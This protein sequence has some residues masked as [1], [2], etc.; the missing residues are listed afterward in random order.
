MYNFQVNQ[1]SLQALLAQNADE[2]ASLLAF[3]ADFE[4]KLA[5]LLVVCLC[6]LCVPNLII[7]LNKGESREYEI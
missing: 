3:K 4:A 1:N 2:L 6:A 5:Q 7:T